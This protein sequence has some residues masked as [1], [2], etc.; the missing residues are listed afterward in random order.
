MTD[1][2]NKQEVPVFFAINEQYAPYVSVAIG[3]LVKTAAKDRE[4]AVYVVNNG[5]KPDTQ[6]KLEG[7]G[8]D[9]VKVQCME[10]GNVLDK[11]QGELATEEWATFFTPTAFF[12][13]FLAELFPQYDKGIYLDADILLRSDI[14]EM[15]D[16]PLGDN[17]LGA[18][19]D[20]ASRISPLFGEYMEQIVGVPRE[21]YVNSGVLLMNFARLRETQFR[22]RFMDLF[23][24]YHFE[25][26]A[27]DQDYINAINKGQIVFL[28]P[29]WDAMPVPGE[30]PLENPKLI[31]YNLFSKPWRYGNVMYG[32]YFWPEAEQ[33]PFYAEILKIRDSITDE[34]R[35]K[36]G[37]NLKLMLNRTQEIMDAD[38]PTL[39][40][41]VVE[42]Q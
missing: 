32:E 8:S 5:L 25:S 13:I 6:Q 24:T 42:R 22:E 35:Q 19:R 26:V 34:E 33:S 28:P 31:H 39:K 9:N 1:Q 20:C 12:R 23:K 30:P 11:I 3:S 40:K 36:D 4:Y 21:E 38:G 2:N 37:E 41:Q 18:C 27:P 29:E 7:L 15:Y 10:M 16:I 17:I 14:G